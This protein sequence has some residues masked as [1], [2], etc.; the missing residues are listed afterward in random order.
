MHEVIY[1]HRE[2]EI[3]DFFTFFSN[4]GDFSMYP[5]FEKGWIENWE[6]YISDKGWNKVKIHY[7][8][9]MMLR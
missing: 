3:K 1:L 6:I 9:L 8:M 5:Y 7:F 4:M 2:L